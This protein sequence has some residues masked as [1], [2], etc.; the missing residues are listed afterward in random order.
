M[1][2]QTYT[3]D[4]H[5]IISTV[6]LEK[7][8]KLQVDTLCKNPEFAHS[9]APLMVWGSPGCGKSSIIKK[10]ANDAGIDF[11]D[12][13]LSQIE[14][15]DLRGLPVPN[16]ENKSVEWFVTGEFPRDPNSRGILL[17]D[18]ITAA[19][20]SLQVAAYELILDRRLGSLYNLPN[21]WL[22]VGAGN[23]ADDRAIST[24]MSS[25]LANRFMHV[26]LV[27]NAEDW[28]AWARQNNIHP[29]VIGFLQYKPSMLFTM[30][31]QNLER[32]WPTPRS[33]ERVSKVCDIC[34]DNQLLRTLVYGLVG[35]GAG[36]E[37]MSFFELNKEF[38]NIL[39]IM[40]NPNSIINIPKEADRRYAMC[41]AMI[42]L[43]W[44]GKTEQDEN[45]RLTGFIRIC[46]EM[47]SDFA[48]MSMLAAMQGATPAETNARSTKI[49][50]N[51]LYKTWLKKHKDAIV[52]YMKRSV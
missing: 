10:V 51:P 49:L 21:G 44:K 5:N 46:T 11:I 27:A 38:D 45:D 7:I 32:G 15:V 18:E 12:F 20:H 1:T 16:K 33:W 48:S 41:S 47:T 14:P 13:R 25:A 50:A 35:N 31:G 4:T 23:K 2:N 6:D 8:L 42:Y 28:Y 26:E 22:I 39:D 37:F 30:E 43:L 17:F 24:T 19:D 3:I 36:V 52:K 40:T 34:D 9:L 29:A